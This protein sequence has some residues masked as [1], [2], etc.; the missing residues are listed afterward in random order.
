MID[1]I[2]GEVAELSDELM[3]LNKDGIGFQL[4]VSQ[5]T[6]ESLK[7]HEG[8]VKIFTYLHVREDELSLYGF[9]TLEER[10]LFRLLISVSG[11]GPKGALSILSNVTPQRF[12]EAVIGERRDVLEEIKGI[13]RKTAER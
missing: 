4:F 1:Y 8:P 2:E 11:V 7:H 9:S 3:V 10:K 5:A 6:R 13:G 12:Q